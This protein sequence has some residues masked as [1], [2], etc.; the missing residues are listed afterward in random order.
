MNVVSRAPGA[1]FVFCSLHQ[2]IYEVGT[3]WRHGSKAADSMIYDI[4]YEDIWYVL[5]L[6]EREKKRDSVQI[7]YP[8]LH[9]SRRNIYKIENALSRSL[10][11]RC[12]NFSEP[13]STHRPPADQQHHQ[14]SARQL[15]V[16]GTASHPNALQQMDRLRYNLCTHT[17]GWPKSFKGGVGLLESFHMEILTGLY[18]ELREEQVPQIIRLKFKIWK[19]YCSSDIVR[20]LTSPHP[21]FFQDVWDSCTLLLSLSIVTCASLFMARINQLLR[22]FM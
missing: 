17:T 10:S 4:T 18:C 3:Y 11:S 5:Y 22:Y 8:R 19:N 7:S 6:G 21:G 16:L 9:L 2:M 12:C 14:A 13:Q 1:K 20:P 15:I